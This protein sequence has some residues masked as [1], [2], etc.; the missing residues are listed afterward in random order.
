MLANIL[1]GIVRAVRRLPKGNVK[2]ERQ[3]N[4]FHISNIPPQPS[5]TNS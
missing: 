1:R 3:L 5:S 2:N 4:M